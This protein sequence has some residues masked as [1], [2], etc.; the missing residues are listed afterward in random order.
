[1]KILTDTYIDNHTDNRIF[2]LFYVIRDFLIIFA[3]Q[4]ASDA[5]DIRFNKRT[6][7]YMG[8]MTVIPFFSYITLTLTD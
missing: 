7:M 8:Q 4:I 5:C 3:L 1:M 2:L 6:C